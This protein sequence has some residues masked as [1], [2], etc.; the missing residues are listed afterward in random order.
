M[1]V[2]SSSLSWQH[3]FLVWL[4]FTTASDVVADFDNQV[5]T[6]LQLS[7][8]L[9]Q[10]SPQGTLA[11]ALSRHSF[12]FTLEV[13]SLE[14]GRVVSVD[15]SPVRQQSIVWSPDERSLV[16]L[17]PS[18]GGSSYDF[19][20]FNLENA[21]R[22]ALGLP[23]TEVI[24]SPIRFSPSGR[25]LLTLTFRTGVATLQSIEY[26][27]HSA[28]VSED[29]SEFLLEEDEGSEENQSQVEADSHTEK[30]PQVYLDGITSDIDYR[31]TPDGQGI[32]YTYE[33]YFYIFNRVSG[34]L[35]KKRICQSC[36]VDSF[37]FAADGSEI[38]VSIRKINDEAFRLYTFSIEDEFLNE[39]LKRPGDILH[40]EKTSDVYSYQH[41]FRE[42][43]T[44]E[45]FDNSA[46]HRVFGPQ[47]GYVEIQGVSEDRLKAYLLHQPGNKP[48]R[49]LEVGLK[50]PE[51]S[52][53]RLYPAVDDNFVLPQYKL[54]QLQSNVRAVLWQV[55]NP[56]GVI[57]YVAPNELGYLAWNPLTA[58][59]LQKSYTVLEINRNLDRG[60]LRRL[61]L[62]RLVLDAAFYA[63][64]ELKT[65]SVSILATGAD[66]S[67]ALAAWSGNP[68]RIEHLY[69]I[70]YKGGIPASNNTKSP[71]VHLFLSADNLNASDRRLASRFRK[72]YD[73][74]SLFIRELPG[75][76]F[77]SYAVVSLALI[78]DAIDSSAGGRGRLPASGR[79]NNALWV[80]SRFLRGESPITGEPLLPEDIERLAETINRHEIRTAFL[81]AGPFGRSGR[82]PPY[83]FSDHAEATIAKLRELCPK[84]RF[85]PWV[86]GT[87]GQNVFLREESWRSRAVSETRKLMSFLGVGGVHI[88]IESVLQQNKDLLALR[89]LE[90]SGS[91]VFGKE[92]V[93]FLSEVRRVLPEAYLSVAVPSTAEEARF[94]KQRL[95]KKEVF[96]LSKQVNQI[97]LQYFDTA[98]DSQHRYLKGLRTQLKHV[99]QWKGLL[100][101]RSPE[102]VLAI[103]TGTNAPSEWNFRDPQI[104][105]FSN[106][107][108]SLRGLE[109]GEKIFFN[110][111][112]IYAN[113]QT[114]PEQWRQL[115]S[116]WLGR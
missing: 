22:R 91:E 92:V 78:V 4:V 43:I 26:L 28:E 108:L 111:I 21:S 35:T 19:I 101:G 79:V 30:K 11:A 44:V 6:M 5:S 23:T 112:G 31:W 45:L 37:V 94:W 114:T 20:Q 16:F 99:A 86:G 82:L 98:I 48:A 60:A 97:T 72:K 102:Y 76:D 52:P 32:A 87:T 64:S 51:Y 95:S 54:I 46:L 69:F 34:E 83:A 13:L 50:S 12:D 96:E 73:L 66:A 116:Y 70:D 27:G 57:V 55:K 62:E 59:L 42:N 56:K 77:S 33:G 14:S 58:L 3:L 115:D 40:L 47:S 38:F 107:L 85:L 74:E 84:V 109:F 81:F 100:R 36:R 2:L 17:E 75:R 53:K 29:T 113:W 25:E 90:S 67:A 88:N 110:G 61:P 68:Q 71:S 65:E 49:A 7:P 39:V 104:E 41:R 106:A 15:R 1:K 9:E 80:Q 10:I 89:E 8:R 93:A 18:G 103:G 105:S 63:E 24:D